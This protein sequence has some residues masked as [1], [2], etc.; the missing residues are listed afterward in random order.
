MQQ[1]IAM[2][3]TPPQLSRQQEIA[4]TSG[5]DLILQ[6][7]A[8]IQLK[9]TNAMQSCMGGRRAWK[10]ESTARSKV[11]R[12]SRHFNREW[13]RSGRNGSLPGPKERRWLKRCKPWRMIGH[14]GSGTLQR[15]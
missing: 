8:Q 2:D 15:C 1:P 7:L 11:S 6:Q 14:T 9:G 4:P 13:S 10:S 12:S 5:T 3:Q